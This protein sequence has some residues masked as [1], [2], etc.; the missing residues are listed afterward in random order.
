MVRMKQA[1]LGMNYEISQLGKMRRTLPI[2][3][4]QKH[5]AHSCLHTTLT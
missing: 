3:N 4:Q 1:T 2:A 5:T